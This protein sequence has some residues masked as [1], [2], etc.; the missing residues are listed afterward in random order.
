LLPGSWIHAQAI[1]KVHTY[2]PGEGAD[3]SIDNEPANSNP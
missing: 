1:I 3:L 2:S